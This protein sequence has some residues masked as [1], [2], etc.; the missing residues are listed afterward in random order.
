MWRAKVFS[1]LE[2]KHIPGRE[3]SK[4]QG[5]AMTSD[6]GR[7]L[8]GAGFSSGI[9]G[10]GVRPEFGASFSSGIRGEIET[11]DPRA[12]ILA[13]YPRSHVQPSAEGIQKNR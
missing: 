1:R 11:G 7:N 10:G 9:R 8:F 12:V 13:F 3:N 4:S 5:I 6:A 2:R